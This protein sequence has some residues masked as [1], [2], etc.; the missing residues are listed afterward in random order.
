M[1][2]LTLVFTNKPKC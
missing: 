1:V 2:L